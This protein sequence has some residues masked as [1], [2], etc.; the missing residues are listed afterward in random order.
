VFGGE[1]VALGKVKLWESFG[2]L[3]LKKV[4]E[5]EKRFC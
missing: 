1:L 2:G 3:R 5:L 4:L